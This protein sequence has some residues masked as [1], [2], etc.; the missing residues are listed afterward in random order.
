MSGIILII[1]TVLIFV[2]ATNIL[3][4]YVAFDGSD[5]KVDVREKITSTTN[6]MRYFTLFAANTL[7]TGV[8]LVFRYVGW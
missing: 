6:Y 5:I 1:S 3:L 8:G 4:Y 2:V 7:I